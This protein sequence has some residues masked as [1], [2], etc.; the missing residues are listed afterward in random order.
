MNRF[1]SLSIR[2]KL[3]LIIMVIS[4]VSLLIASAALIT[5]DRV[6]I[7]EAVGSNLTTLT[8]ILAAHNSA[9]ILFRDNTAAEET[10]RFL[11]RHENIEAAGI[12]DINGDPVAVYR[13]PGFTRPLP[14]VQTQL[15][16]VLFWDRH[17]D[18]ARRVIHDGD[19]IGYAY[20]R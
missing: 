2:Q 9:A 3:M 5:T 19:T 20:I 18:T 14:D 12:F 7:R 16:N 11:A 10:L 8:E 17:V 1:H 6:K 4:T 13:K 15:D